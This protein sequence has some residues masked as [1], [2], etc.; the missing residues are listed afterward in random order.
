MTPLSHGCNTIRGGL[1]E[2][3]YGRGPHLMGLSASVDAV[4]RLGIGPG[5]SFTCIPIT[6]IS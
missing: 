6:D 4:T 2:I 5:D 1:R 3:Y